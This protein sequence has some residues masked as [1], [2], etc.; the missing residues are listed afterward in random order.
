MGMYEYRLDEQVALLTMNESKFNIDSVTEFL[1]VLNEIEKDTNAKA[2]IVRS[3]NEKMWSTGL[4]LE[5]LLP[6][7]QKGERGVTD[8]FPAKLTELFKIMLF[9]PMITVAAIPGHAFAGGG[10]PRHTITPQLHRLDEESYTNGSSGRYAAH[11]QETDCRGVRS[12]PY[13]SES[14][15]YGRTG[16]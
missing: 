6:L 12:P 15:H 8:V 10:E 14:L 3:S 2:L 4:D 1:S 16:E 5:W 9:Y 11:C 7:I 13:Y